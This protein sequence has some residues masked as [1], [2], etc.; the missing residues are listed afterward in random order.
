MVTSP[1]AEQEFVAHLFAPLDGP[2]AG[3][4]AEQLGLLF[5]ACRT[6][7]GMTH[8]IA[9]TDLPAGLPADPH[10]APDG[11]LAA[12]EDPDADF[13]AIVR[14][15]HDVLVLSLAMAT[16]E[17]RRRRMSPGWVEYARWWR[18]LAAGGLSA[19]LGGVTVYQ[20]KS[21]DGVRAGVREAVPEQDDDGAHWW[22]RGTTAGDFAVWEVTPG[23]DRAVRRLVVLGRP[24]E[25]AELSAFTWSAGDVAL[26]PLGRYLMHAAKLRYAARVRGDG[27]RLAAVRAATTARLDRITALLSAGAFAGEEAAGLAADEAAVAG[28]LQ[29]LRDMRRGVEIAADNM[30]RSLAEP[31]PADRVL[32]DVLDQRLADDLYYLEQVHLRAGQTRQLIPAPIHAEPAR[33]AL[34]APVAQPVTRPAPGPPSAVEQ[35][36]GLGVD[37]VKY[38]DRSTPQ[39]GAVQTRLAGI[40][41]RVLGVAGLAL[42]DTDHQDAGDGM[43]IV[44]PAHVPPHLALPKLLNAWRAQ[45]AVDNAEHPEDRIRLRLSMTTGPFSPSAIGF[46]GATIIETGRLLDSDALRRAVVDHPAADLVALISDRLHADVVG[47]GY[48]GLNADHFV[49]VRVQVKSYDRTAWL[50]L[51]APL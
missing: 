14:R 44:L 33:S 37:V 31:L 41:E 43:M 48:P 15:E 42:R 30:T 34:R 12:I 9:R 6:Q 7:L 47:E 46:T 24:G 36:M 45:V 19:F 18:R 1:P 35:R 3:L 25:D 4:A 28:T 39:Q 51:G 22:T 40:V 16:P 20:A 8:R 49:R 23:G 26:P 32:A 38:S 13:Q 50:W 2:D 11:P 29:S 21:P 10:A 17:S 5:Q 27:S